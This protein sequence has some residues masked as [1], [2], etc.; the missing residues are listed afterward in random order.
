MCV[1]IYNAINLPSSGRQG[2]YSMQHAVHLDISEI[3]KDSKLDC[4]Q[5]SPISRMIII[6]MQ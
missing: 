4:L 1:I 5:L 3:K 2:T 6:Y